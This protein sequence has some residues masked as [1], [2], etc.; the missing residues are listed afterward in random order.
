[1][2]LDKDWRL[3][4]LYLPCNLAVLTMFLW[5]RPWWSGNMVLRSLH[6]SMKL[7]MKLIF[8]QG[9]VR[10]KERAPMFVQ[11]GLLI[12][13][14]LKKIRGWNI[15][16]SLDSNRKHALEKNVL[17]LARSKIELETTPTATTTTTTTTTTPNPI[18]AFPMNVFEQQQVPIEVS[19]IGRMLV[20]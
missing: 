18:S 19:R 12:D 2:R 7:K 4:S 9:V 15:E 8:R 3:P 1:M 11:V 17:P 6:S 13:R 14:L 16:A 5:L 10:L 20:S